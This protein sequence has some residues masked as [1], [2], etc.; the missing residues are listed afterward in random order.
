MSLRLGYQTDSFRQSWDP[1]LWEQVLGPCP[2]AGQTYWPV[3]V[4]EQPGRSDATASGPCPGAGLL[5]ASCGAKAPLHR[6][7]LPNFLW[8]GAPK[9][10]MDASS[11]LVLPLQ[12]V[13]V[14]CHS[15]GLV[16]CRFRAGVGTPGRGRCSDHV[17]AQARFTG[18][19]RCMSI[20]VGAMQRRL[21]HVL[22]QAC[23]R[24]VAVQ[25]RRCIVCDS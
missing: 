7:R 13:F 4:C 15:L 24:L 8:R 16:C 6:L 12:F 17:L 3:A 19:L 18:L 9:L 1:N 11:G 21:N 2:C 22:A 25:R 20:L 14:S 23:Y 10:L 5:Q